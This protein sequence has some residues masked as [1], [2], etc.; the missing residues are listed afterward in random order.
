MDAWKHKAVEHAIADL[1]REACGLVVIIKGRMR[2]WPCKNLATDQDFFFLDP[3]DWAEAEDTG[4]IA[5]VFHS[6]PHCDC[7][8]SQADRVA[9]EKS[10]VPWYIY[11]PHNEGWATL[12]PEGYKAP[13]IGRQWVW[14]VTDCWSLVRDWYAEEFG[15]ELRD[16]PRP[17]AMQTFTEDP[18]F[19]RCWEETGFVEVP[20]EEIQ[21]GDAILMSIEN[22]GLNHVGVYA[23]HQ[24]LLHHLRGRLSS[25]DIYGGY[26]L[27]ST[28]R[29]LRHTNR[30]H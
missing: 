16:W 10:G 20:M 1:T 23:D 9:C 13:L 3:E 19:D 21:H 27:K 26:Y 25:R 17:A 5:A 11:S 6:H 14:G 30:M 12:K 4:E 24:M 18:Q 7:A 2:Y 22:H 15:I 28:G 8:P 29:I